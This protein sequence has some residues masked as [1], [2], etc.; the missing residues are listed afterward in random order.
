MDGLAPRA[1]GGNHRIAIDIDRAVALGAVRGH[2]RVVAVGAEEDDLAGAGRRHGSDDG[3]GCIQHRIAIGRHVLHDDALEHRQVFHRGDEVQ[4]QVV[5]FANVGDHRHGAAVKPQAFAQDAAT[6]GFEYCCIHL[7][8]QQHIARAFGATA[9][10]A[11]DLAAVDVHAIGIGHAYPQALGGKEV[12]NQACRRGLAIGAGHSHHRNAS[13]AARREHQI[14]HGLANRAR[15]AVRGRQVHAQAGRGV[16]FDN[17]TGLL[18][19]GVQHALA[20]QVDAAD[21]QPHHLRGR[22]GARR[23]VGVHIIG[24]VGGRAASGEVGVVAQ[25]DA[26]ALGRD[27]VGRQPLCGE[28]RYGNVVKADLGER[29]GMA[30]APARVEVDQ[31]HQFAHGVDVVAQH[32]RRLTPRGGHELIAHH[33]QAE[34][35]PGQK[36]LDHDLAVFGG[37][38]KGFIEL[39]ALGDIDRDALALVAILGLDY[40]GQADIERHGPG[41]VHG[42]GGPPHGH[43]DAGGVQQ[44]LGQIFVLRDGFGHGAGRIDFGC[45]DAALA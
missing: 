41:F 24:D 3:V 9:V 25:D 7:G 31:V 43:G 40:H 45:L 35:V 5:A 13:V 29:C 23:H 15:L 19:D 28:T 34:V 30:L 10:A 12:G 6:R 37:H 21:V 20:D 36:A 1:F 16:D 26:L 4:P 11:V 38:A 2:H 44:A 17:A 18:F 39:R 22:H 27:R 42:S 33:Q 32:L 8:V 14:H